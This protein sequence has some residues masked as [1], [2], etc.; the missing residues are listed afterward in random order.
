M[1][2]PIYRPRL[3]EDKLEELLLGMIRVAIRTLP[4][5]I[6]ATITNTRRSTSSAMFE[7]HV[8]D[9]RVL[10]ADWSRAGETHQG[11]SADYCTCIFCG[12]G[13]ANKQGIEDHL[14]HN[15]CDV[16]G[17]I[18]TMLRT[19]FCKTRVWKDEVL[20]QRKKEAEDARNLCVV[21]LD[22][23]HEKISR[24]HNARKD[25]KSVEPRL[26]ALGFTKA[27]HK[28]Q[29]GVTATR[30]EMTTDTAYALADPREEGRI[31][32]RAW[33]LT[34]RP[35]SKRALR[36]Y[37]RPEHILDGWCNDLPKKVQA[38]IEKQLT[39]R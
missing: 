29:G 31:Y 25:L 9:L 37:C 20:A 26:K 14:L 12:S 39:G 19:E 5:P 3:D 24:G 21:D 23:G 34:G 13:V 32:I 22:R 28:L 10:G 35:G 18:K 6:K 16:H 7:Q 2:A 27:V 11:W 17:A 1:N 33:P 30:W 38:R 8:N 4:E 15:R 36:G